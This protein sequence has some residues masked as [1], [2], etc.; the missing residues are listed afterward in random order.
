M[1]TLYFMF[2]IDLNDFRY[3]IVSAFTSKNELPSHFGKQY[4]A[5]TFDKR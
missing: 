3:L 2:T 4:K 1:Y 5:V